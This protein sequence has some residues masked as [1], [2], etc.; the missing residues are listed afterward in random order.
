MN[1]EIGCCVA[2]KWFRMS[3][4]IDKTSLWRDLNKLS[5][6]LCKT[7]DTMHRMYR[8]TLGQRIVDKSLDLLVDWNNLYRADEYHLDV[9]EA[10]AVFQRDFEC[11]KV[12]ISTGHELGQINRVNFPPILLLFDSATRQFEGY[13]KKVTRVLD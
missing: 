11:L 3:G 13:C 9:K 7:C 1:G 5:L 8:H 4:A 12:L 6:S 2:K 10:F